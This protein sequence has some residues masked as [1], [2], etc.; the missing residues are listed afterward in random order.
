MTSDQWLVL[1]VICIIEKASETY[2]KGVESYSKGG[3]DLE[4]YTKGGIDG[5]I[6]TISSLD[7]SLQILSPAFN[8]TR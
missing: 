3:V 1:D 4:S 2:P 7:S 8:H 5:A 6:S